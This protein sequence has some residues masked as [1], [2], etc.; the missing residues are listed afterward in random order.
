M[1]III[2]GGGNVGLHIAKK[3]KEKKQS[4]IIID[5]SEERIKTIREILDINIV[6]GN[7][8][9][10]DVLEKA[11]IKSANMVIAVMEKDDANILAC[12]LT[13][14]FSKDITTVARVRNPES[15]G[16]IDIDT[17]G[18]TQKQVGL[19]VIISPEKAMAQELLKIIFFPDVDEVEY[20]SGEKVKLIG[21]VI[22][23]NTPIR[24]MKLNEFTM[25]SSSKIIGITDKNGKFRFPGAQDQIE[26]GDKIYL[27][28]T[29]SA[30]HS[31]SRL[32]YEKESIVERVLILGGGMTGLT[33]AQ[34]LE[35]APDRSFN[36]KIIEKDPKRC[37]QLGQSLKKTL[38]IQGDHSEKAYFNE[39]EIEETDVLVV[40][41]GDD[42]INLIASILGKDLGVPKIINVLGD[43]GYASIYPKMKVSPVINPQTITAEK[44]LRY[45]HKEEVASL[46]V[47]EEDVEVFEVILQGGCKVSGVKI[48]ESNFP[49]GVLI[50]AII[51]GGSVIMPEPN[52]VLEPKDHLVVVA[53]GKV[54]LNL[55]DYF[56]C[57]NN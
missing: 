1:H 51:R 34:D 56:T 14:T 4:V 12:M 23:K 17:Y 40:G 11:N 31:A 7:G 35:S 8:A 54:S 22:S 57:E 45:V 28:G 27:L 15:A 32:L 50:G 3:L 29:I 16:S 19:D 33:L 20:F 21:K 26:E 39:E 44:I 5:N 2:I 18:L 49:E 41:T 6:Q 42:R 46:A 48:S 30:M 52:T 55:E 24:G 25:P 13:K 9:N 37:E 36:T 47:L 10:I 53:L 43:M 38:V